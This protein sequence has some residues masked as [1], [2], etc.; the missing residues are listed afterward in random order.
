[1]PP[2][3]FLQSG[4]DSPLR[5][6][7]VPTSKGLARPI[8]W[9]V[10]TNARNLILET[11]GASLNRLE[12]HDAGSLDDGPSVTQEQPAG[13]VRLRAHSFGQGTFFYSRFQDAIVASTS[14][15]DV[16]ALLSAAHLDPDAVAGYFACGRCVCTDQSRTFVEGVR[17]VPA[18]HELKISEN[19]VALVRCSAPIADESAIL[20]LPI[21]ASRL[22]STLEAVI[23]KAANSAARPAALVSGGLDSSIVAALLLAVAAGKH[24][25]LVTLRHGLDCPE[26]RGLQE[27]LALHLGRDLYVP[28]LGQC[29]VD[30][31]SLEEANKGAA[32]PSGGLFTGIYRE[33]SEQLKDEGIDLLFGGEGGDE[34]FAYG[35]ELVADLLRAREWR[36]ALLSAARFASEDSEASAATILR[37]SLPLA[38]PR[39]PGIKNRCLPTAQLRYQR[40]LRLLLGDGFSEPLTSAFA[41]YQEDLLLESAGGLALSSYINYRRS[42]EVPFYEPLVGCSGA[43]WPIVC[44]PLSQRA[45]VVL[46]CSLELKARQSGVGNFGTKP[47]LR[48]I[49]EG[50]L[51]RPVRKA[52]KVGVANLVARVTQGKESELVARI[53][54]ANLDDLGI[55]VSPALSD[56]RAVP[57][58]FSLSWVLL[59]LLVVWWRELCGFL[60]RH[61]A[62]AERVGA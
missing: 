6:V 32:A 10:V 14:L 62:E 58:E 44:N 41:R 33:A 40:F 19:G 50:L 5:V 23:G 1:V 42:I 52:P 46:G 43:P 13:T 27:A 34:A 48:A 55:S 57:S 12:V 38:W 25:M 35:P 51:P 60:S 36:L 18:G 21:A 4:M 45:A 61:Q 53:V 49:S 2:T 54:T 56:P 20:T 17:C 47:L 30:L 15:R 22:R 39:C 28:R 11:N 7:V 3:Y 31:S 26:E 8:R 29:R 16:A 59:L 24:P 37:E 9:P